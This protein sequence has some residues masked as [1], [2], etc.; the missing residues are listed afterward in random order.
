VDFKVAVGTPVKAPFTGVIKRKNW[1]F[2]GNGNSLELEELDGKRRRALF[3]HLSELPK[4]LRPGA[5]FSTGQV[6]A[7]SGNSGRSFAPHLHYQLMTQDDRVVD[8]FDSHRRV[9][10]SL[11]AEQ[12]P[13]LEAEVRRLDSL[14]SPPV[15]GN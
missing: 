4:S 13:A 14:L 2:S 5:R 12:R 3:L 11:P 7:H 9:R 1:N 6:L 15:A 10:R 8:P